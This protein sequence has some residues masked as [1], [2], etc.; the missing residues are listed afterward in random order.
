MLK[1]ALGKVIRL[2]TMQELE[3]LLVQ[4]QHLVAVLMAEMPLV[5]TA[6]GVSGLGT[7]YGLA[8]VICLE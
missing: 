7:L 3:L 2:V 4:G 6:A 5:Y 1:P 8:P